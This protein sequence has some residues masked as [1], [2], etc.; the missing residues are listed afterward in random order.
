MKKDLR[1]VAA[2]FSERLSKGE[3]VSIAEGIHIYIDNRRAVCCQGFDRRF[4]CLA[5]SF[6]IILFKAI[7]AGKNC[8]R[9]NEYESFNN[10]KNQKRRRSKLDFVKVCPV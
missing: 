10:E 6:M 5:P 3:I 7:E 1:R 4:Y 8:G 9:F 2:K